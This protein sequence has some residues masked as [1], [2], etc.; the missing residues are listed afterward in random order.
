MGGPEAPVL[1]GTKIESEK[2]PGGIMPE[3]GRFLFPNTQD[4]ESQS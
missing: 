3:S 1:Q 4:F 2:P